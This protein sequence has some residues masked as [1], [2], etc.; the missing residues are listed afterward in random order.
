MC[1]NLHDDDSA[2]LV[3][4]IVPVYNNEERILRCLNS[5][6]ENSCGNIEVIAVDD[7][8]TDKS[9]ERILSVDDSR[10]RYVYQKNS[11]P[12]CARNRGIEMARGKWIMFVDSDD[13]VKPDAVRDLLFVAEKKEADIVCFDIEKKIAA[14]RFRYIREPYEAESSWQEFFRTFVLH[15]GLCSLWNKLFKKSLFH[16]IRLFEDIRLGEDSSALLRVLPYAK[17]IIHLNKALYVYDLTHDG[18]S[19]N[20]KRNVLD[21]MRAARLTEKFY[22]DNAIELP[23]PACLLRL[24]I[25]YYTLYFLPLGKARKIGYMDY[26]FVAEDFYAD[27][28]KI[29]SSVEFQMIGFKYKAFSILYNVYYPLF[30]RKWFLKNNGGRQCS[31][32]A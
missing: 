1:F 16:N 28:T 19:R 11:G 12:S 27:F 25:C 8:S 15:N 5:I 21:Y 6:L 22:E 32:Q 9:G 20:A 7:G 13:Y 26:F 30:H 2:P 23:L 24:K 4:V 31:P 14:E 29:V 18:I 10:I 3:S 17:K